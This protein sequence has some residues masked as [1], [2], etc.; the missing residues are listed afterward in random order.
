M[1]S[2]H[3]HS[4]KT[5]HDLDG[6]V[7]MLNLNVVETFKTGRKGY[8]GVVCEPPEGLGND[9]VPNLRGQQVTLDGKG[10]V[11]IEGI[12]YFACMP[13]KYIMNGCISIMVKGANLLGSTGL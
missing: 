5:I 11:T 10:V 3:C 13:P 6:E 9:D 2:C 4:I 8:F 7:K 12:E 1:N